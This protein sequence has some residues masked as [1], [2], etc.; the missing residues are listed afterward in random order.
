MFSDVAGEI[1]SQFGYQNAS[2]SQLYQLV[3][4]V[5]TD[6]ETK[7]IDMGALTAEYM[8]RLAENFFPPELV[9]REDFRRFLLD[10]L[11]YGTD[12]EETEESLDFA[13]DDLVR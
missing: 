7:N 10:R 11:L 9:A 4:V 1:R 3:K 6:M 5:Q 13:S 2:A 8:G 12:T